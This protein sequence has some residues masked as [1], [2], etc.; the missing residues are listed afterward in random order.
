MKKLFTLFLLSATLLLGCKKDEEVKP[1]TKSELIARNW[2]FQTATVSL[3]T[4]PVTAYTKGGAQNLVDF[5]SSYMNFKSDGS[6]SQVL[7]PNT[8]LTGTWKLNTGE[9]G[10]I[11]TSSSGAV[12][13]WTIDNL[14]ETNLNFSR[15]IAGNTTD[16]S[17]LSW[18]AL[19]KAYGFSTANG[20]KIEVKAVPNP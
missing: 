9:T 1:K 2:Q 6:F 11:V 3:G 16:P 10:F 15:Q 13:N 12:D 20:A 17:D 5:S 4:V 7:L 14:T 8:S 19:I 18:L